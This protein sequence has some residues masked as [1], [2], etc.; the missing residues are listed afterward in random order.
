MY[1]ATCELLQLPS[2]PHRLAFAA[3]GLGLED[4][5]TSM[6]AKGSPEEMQSAHAWLE[7]VAES[8]GID[9][10]LQQHT[11]GDVLK[12]TSVV[13][14]NRS[15]PAAPVTAFLIGLAAGQRSATADADELEVIAKR[16][17]ATITEKAQG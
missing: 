6:P 1:T 4:M 9:P 12:L 3:T 13:A 5:S 2:P 11:V 16:L 8:L 17:L 14:H 15:R 7:E 10:A